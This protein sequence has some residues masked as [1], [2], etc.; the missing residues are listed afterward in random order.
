MEQTDKREWGGKN[1]NEDNV[2]RDNRDKDKDKDRGGMDI[3]VSMSL[4]QM[5]VVTPVVSFWYPAIGNTLLA[6]GTTPAASVQ[7]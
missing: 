7:T 2:S 3:P 4:D 1:Q 6:E 5:E